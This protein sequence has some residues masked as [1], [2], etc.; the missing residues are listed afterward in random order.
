MAATDHHDL[1][2]GEAGPPEF[3]NLNGWATLSMTPVVQV[4]GCLLSVPIRSYPFLSVP[5]RSCPF[6]SVPTRFWF[7]RCPFLSVVV[8]SIFLLSVPHTEW[9]GDAYPLLSNS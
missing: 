7:Y 6:L 8:C 1:R 5:T 3:D 2:A 9:D 4:H